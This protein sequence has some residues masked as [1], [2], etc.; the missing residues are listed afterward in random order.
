MQIKCLKVGELKTNCYLLI[1]HNEMA[2]IDLGGEAEKVL[3]EIKETKAELKY[4][5]N[6]HYHFD[7]VLADEKIKSQ[8]PEAKILIHEAEKDFIDFKA[9]KFLKDGDEIKI[10]DVV[11][12]VIHTPGHTL[13]GIC[14]FGDNFIFTGDTLFKNG[15]GRTDLAGGSEKDLIKSLEKLEKLLKPGMTIYSGHGEIFK[16]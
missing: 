8:E 4:I 16:T 3:E 15:Y 2:V 6:T 14:L 1:S 5:I 7:H 12:K 13:G 11:L 10:G 9:D